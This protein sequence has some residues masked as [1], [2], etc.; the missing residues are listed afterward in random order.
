MT[1]SQEFMYAPYFDPIESDMSGDDGVLVADTVLDGQNDFDDDGFA[2]M[3]ETRYG[4]NPLVPN[5]I[6]DLEWLCCPE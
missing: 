2:N 4:H 3:D 5:S 1:N 6:M